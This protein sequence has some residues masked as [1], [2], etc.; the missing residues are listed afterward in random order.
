MIVVGRYW[1]DFNNQ[2]KFFVSFARERNFDPLIAENWYYISK[3][4]VAHVKVLYRFYKNLTRAKTNQKKGGRNI[5][6]FH[7]HSLVTTLQYAFPN[8]EFNTE[9]FSR[10]L[11]GKLILHQNH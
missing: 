4:E 9:K 5:L 11:T 10:T 6:G 8:V 1:S 7:K 3:E 2:H